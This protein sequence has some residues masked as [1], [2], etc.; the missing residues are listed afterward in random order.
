MDIYN[1]EINVIDFH[2]HGF[3][4]DLAERA[5]EKL[6]SVSKLTPSTDGTIRGIKASM[7]SAGVN[8]SVVLPIATKPQQTRKINQWAVSVQDEDIIAFG[9]VHPDY[10]DWECELQWLKASGIKGIKFH[11][12]YQWFDVDDE[13]MFP[14]YEKAAELGL[15]MIFHAGADIGFPPPYHCMPERLRNVVRSFPDAK[16]VAAHM[17]GYDSW[18]EVERFLVGESLYFD[19]SFSLHKMDR[20]QFMRIG[21]MHGFER[22]LFATDSPWGSQHDELERLG[23]MGLP[24]EI[25]EAILGGNAAKLLGLTCQAF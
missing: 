18:N 5:V 10:E 23:K 12:E 15:I 20:E 8:K 22:L 11:P 13:R 7:K 6:A 1:R 19:T 9:T 25:L 14:I 24:D 21:Y 17:G 16:I 2:V 4:D 3:A